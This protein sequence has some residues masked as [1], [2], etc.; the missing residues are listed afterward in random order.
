MT[1]IR[2]ELSKLN[3][4]FCNLMAVQENFIALVEN[5]DQHDIESRWFEVVDKEVMDFKTNIHNY[6]SQAENLEDN[7]SVTSLFRERAAAEKARI[8]ELH[9]ESKFLEERRA[10]E[11]A[12]EKV[13]IKQE[14]AKAEARVKVFEEFEDSIRCEK[15]VTEEVADQDGTF[16]KNER[17]SHSYVKNWITAN[18]DVTNQPGFSQRQIIEPSR[19]QLENLSEQQQQQA[20]SFGMRRPECSQPYVPKMP[21]EELPQQPNL[22]NHFINEPREDTEGI[23]ESTLH[24]ATLYGLLNQQNAP[25]VDIDVFGGD[26]MEY[27]YFM[28]TFRKVVEKKIADPMGRLTRLIKYTSGEAKELIRHCIQ[29]PP[30]VCYKEAK[31]LLTKVWGFI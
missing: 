24:A 5:C 8:A 14:I 16:Y 26:P 2:C 31:A 12:S 17:I 3:E 15:S 7:K 30:K 27:Q 25:N 28:A 20:V 4:I 21:K 18:R 9:A 6:L 11:I 23:D 29:L 10:A 19:V 22:G 13:R 1:V